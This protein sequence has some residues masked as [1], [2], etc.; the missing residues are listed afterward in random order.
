MLG[1]GGGVRFEDGAGGGRGA[2]E[3]G[4]G[5][6]MGGEGMPEAADEGFREAGGGIGGFF[7]TGGGG[8]GLLMDT[9]EPE[10]WLYG[11]GRRLFFNA[12]T[13]GGGGGAAADGGNGGAPG[14]RGADPFGMGGAFGELEDGL[15][16]LVSGSES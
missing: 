8:F 12:A 16:L 10:S 1:G 6:A 5:G 15:R 7:P 2:L 9:V 11:L 3:G 13:F 14:G 4:R